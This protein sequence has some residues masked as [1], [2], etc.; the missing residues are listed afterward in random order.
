ML[1]SQAFGIPMANAEQTDQNEPSNTDAEEWPPFLH[2]DLHG[3]SPHHMTSPRLS[4][5]LT[6]DQLMFPLT[7]FEGV[8]DE[9]MHLLPRPHHVT[10]PCNHRFGPVLL[11]ILVSLRGLE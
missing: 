1:T 9:R 3:P 7:L 11:L 8:L 6:F 5:G 4:L 10:S 2:G